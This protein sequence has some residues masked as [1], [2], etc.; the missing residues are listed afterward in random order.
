MEVETYLQHLG[1][2]FTVFQPL[3]IYGPHT[4]KDCEQWFMD[5]I[6]RRASAWGGLGWVVGDTRHLAIH[7]GDFRRLRSLDAWV[8]SAASPGP[9]LP[10]HGAA[11]MGGRGCSCVCSRCASYKPAPGSPPSKAAGLS[12][13]ARPPAQGPPRAHPRARRA[14]H[15]HLSRGGPGGHDGAGARQLGRRGPALQPVQRPL[16]QLRG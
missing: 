13:R 10:A 9:A 6:L 16:H 4:A 7:G 11:D 2:P 3:Y 5:R 14:A 12:W 8:Q 1:M 15:L